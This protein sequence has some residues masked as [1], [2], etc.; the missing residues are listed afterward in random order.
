MPEPT[1]PFLQGVD[2]LRGTYNETEYMYFY[3]NFGTHIQTSTTFGSA[4]YYNA[5][6]SDIL[7]IGNTGDLGTF[8]GQI[9]ESVQEYVIQFQN[10]DNDSS[11]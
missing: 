2:K 10:A 11:S 5:L 3:Q 9:N 7:G 8:E 4:Y 1:L 6:W